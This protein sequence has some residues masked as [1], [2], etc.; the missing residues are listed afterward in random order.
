MSNKIK[1]TD[2]DL[3]FGE[4]VEDFLPPPSELIPKQKKVE[5]KL[6][7]AEEKL[8]LIEKE[9]NKK[10]ISSQD[11]IESIIDKYIPQLKP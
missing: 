11:L 5:I 6:N 2:Q 8:L 1:Y 10:N 9:A 7:L 4:I 3:E